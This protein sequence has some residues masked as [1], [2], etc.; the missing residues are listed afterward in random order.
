MTPIE[1]KNAIQLLTSNDS[2]NSL[3]GYYTLKGFGGLDNLE[4][5]TL[6]VDVIMKKGKEKWFK[7]F[8]TKNNLTLYQKRLSRTI[9]VYFGNYSIY[10]DSLQDDF[11]VKK[12]KKN[13][14]RILFI[15]AKNYNYFVMPFVSRLRIKQQLVIYFTLLL[16]LLKL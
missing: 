15:N 10:V 11:E 4:I 5:A 7:V 16:E 6:F 2:E 12:N 13:K 14:Y 8:N 9:H 3:I 1:K